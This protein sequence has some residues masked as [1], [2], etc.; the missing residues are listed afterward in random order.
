MNPSHRNRRRNNKIVK[1]PKTHFNIGT[2]I[3][4]MIFIYIIVVSFNYLKKEPLSIYEVTEKQMS[5]DNFVVGFA[6][7][8][9]T[10]YNADISGTVA[11]YNGKSKKC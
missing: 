10:V 1:Y 4:I 3:F 6:M 5:D 11:F 8:D 9:E 2:I 7:R